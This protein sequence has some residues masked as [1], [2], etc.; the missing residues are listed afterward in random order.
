MKR[1]SVENLTDPI[2]MTVVVKGN[3]DHENYS[4]FYVLSKTHL[5]NVMSNFE[6]GKIGK[7][8]IS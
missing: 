6:N 3:R 8:C 2:F 4:T 1:C 5:L 7:M